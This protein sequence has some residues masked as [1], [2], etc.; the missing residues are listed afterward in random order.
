IIQSMSRK[1]RED[2]DLMDGSRRRRIAKGS[3]TQAEDVAK[4]VKG[5]MSARDMVKKMSG[6]SMGNRAKMAQA[7]TQFDVTKLAPGGGRPRGALICP[8]RLLPVRLPLPKCH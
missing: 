3:G 6:M 5:F 2:P 7:M 4:L 1:E 8:S